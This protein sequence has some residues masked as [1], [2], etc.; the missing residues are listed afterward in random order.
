MIIAN[1]ISR[2]TSMCISSCGL[3]SA[4][5]VAW[6]ISACALQRF[7]VPLMVKFVITIS[8]ESSQLRKPPCHSANVTMILRLV[9]TISEHSVRSCM[10]WLGCVRKL[11]WN[12]SEYPH[13]DALPSIIVRNL[14]P[15]LALVPVLIPVPSPRLE[16]IP[17]A[18][19]LLHEDE[20]LASCIST[21]VIE[22]TTCVKHMDK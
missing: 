13:R 17:D 1:R 8:G 2:R 14:R 7:R 4:C 16:F 19:Q 20:C 22:G 11:S 12:A 9:W 15:A 10:R 5:A 21:G 3:C 6:S 18:S